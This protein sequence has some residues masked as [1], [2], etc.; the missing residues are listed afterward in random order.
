MLQACAY[1]FRDPKY[2]DDKVMM[3]ISSLLGTFP[4]FSE[5]LRECQNETSISDN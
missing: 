2:T 4:L 5:L 3:A 1:A